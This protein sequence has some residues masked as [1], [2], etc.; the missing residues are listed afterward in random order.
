MFITLLLISVQAPAAVVPPPKQPKICREGAHQTGS[1]MRSM[2][3]CLTAEQWRE[4]DAKRS[5]LPVSAQITE[6][7][8]DTGAGQR[9]Q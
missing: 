3:R 4:E 6:G 7:Q 9:P 5:G 2:R 8:P 1:H